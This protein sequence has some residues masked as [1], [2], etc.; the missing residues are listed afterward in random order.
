MNFAEIKQKYAIDAVRNAAGASLKPK[1]VRVEFYGKLYDPQ[2]GEYKDYKPRV[3]KIT[4]PAG[5]TNMQNVPA[6]LLDKLCSQ[7]F[8][9]NFV[10]FNAGVGNPNAR[11]DK[12]G[13]IRNPNYDSQMAKLKKG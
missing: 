9:K 2:K 7:K 13:D 1:S 12:F 3:A 6:S 10:W 11:D 8:E 5:I 4:I